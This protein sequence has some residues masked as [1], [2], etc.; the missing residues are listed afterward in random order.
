MKLTKL[1]AFQIYV[2]ENWPDLFYRWFYFN[3][4]TKRYEDKMSYED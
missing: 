2:F 1:S 3:P 4:E